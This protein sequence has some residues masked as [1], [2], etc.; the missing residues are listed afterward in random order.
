VPLAFAL[1]TT[2]FYRIGIVRAGSA[3]VALVA[4]VWFVERA[5]DIR[6]AGFGA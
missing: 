3:V 2:R 6:L 5:F 4:T 1:R